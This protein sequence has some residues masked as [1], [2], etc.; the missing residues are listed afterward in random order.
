[1]SDIRLHRASDW[2]CGHESSGGTRAHSHCRGLY[3]K[4]TTCFDSAEVRST[5]KCT[6]TIAV[7]LQSKPLHSQSMWSAWCVSF[8]SVNE[9]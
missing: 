5:K 1:M 6:A 3:T 8:C 7:I 4:P 9:L 2:R